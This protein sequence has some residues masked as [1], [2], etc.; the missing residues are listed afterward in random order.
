MR[1]L[2]G[3]KKRIG[4]ALALLLMMSFSACIGDKPNEAL[5]ARGIKSSKMQR[6]VITNNRYAGRYT[7]ID[8]KSISD[9]ANDVVMASNATEDSKLEPDF[10][11]EFYN[12]IEKVATFKYIAGINGK[13][14]ANLIDENGRLY[15]MSSSIEDDFMNRMMNKDNYKNVSEYYISL[16]KLLAGKVKVNSGDTIAVDISKDYI[17]TRSITSVEQK[18]I[19]DNVDAGGARILF[20]SET[21]SQKYLIKINTDSYTDKSS[22]GTASITDRKNNVVKYN[23]IGTYEG[24]TWDY[25]ITYKQY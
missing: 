20:P 10:I 14:T 4:I 21:K 25:H 17:V 22:S 23:I 12:D 13:K 5:S 18:D 24:G 7:I 16:L 3:V 9:F 15:H 6:I 2:T 11:I 1:I 19:L 8:K